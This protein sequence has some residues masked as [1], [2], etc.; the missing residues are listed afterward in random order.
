[1]VY[2]SLPRLAKKFD[3]TYIERLTKEKDP[4]GKGLHRNGIS[5]LYNGDTNGIQFETLD[6]LCKSLEC[7]VA[8]LIEYVPDED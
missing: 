5:K 3:S 8:D 1:M 2:F 6:L 4:N 7:T